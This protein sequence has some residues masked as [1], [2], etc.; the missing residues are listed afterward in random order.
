MTLSVSKS[1]GDNL[2]EGPRNVRIS[3]VN[4]DAFAVMIDQ[5]AK[6]GPNPI[7]HPIPV[8][9]SRMPP[10]PT[11]ATECPTIERKE[12]GHFA[13]VDENEELDEDE[14]GS[15]GLNYMTLLSS[16]IDQVSGSAFEI[17]DTKTSIRADGAE[18]EPSNESDE[19]EGDF[20]DPTKSGDQSAFFGGLLSDAADG[21][22]MTNRKS[23]SG[24]RSKSEQSSNGCAVG[25]RERMNSDPRATIAEPKTTSFGKAGA[26]KSG[27]AEVT[28]TLSLPIFQP[29]ERFH[30]SIASMV[31]AEIAKPPQLIHVVNSTVLHSGT[32]SRA[33]ELRIQIH[34]ENFGR[35]TIQL[36]ESDDC[37][38]VLVRTE[39]EA[40]YTKL[41]SEQE[42]LFRCL[43]A[44]GVNI[45]EVAIEL[46][47]TA[48]AN[49]VLRQAGEI[50]D[51]TFQRPGNR[52]DHRENFRQNISQECTALVETST[53]R[54][55]RQAGI[56]I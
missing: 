25:W 43:R 33:T 22:T 32:H 47:P 44:Q 35:L 6:R 39:S 3:G 51:G 20:T 24:N 29:A 2:P 46:P 53:N 15:Q 40:A 27:A 54:E 49:A 30:S 12:A 23:I 36:R 26:T 19:L 9:H 13:H 38:R 16:G 41:A 55:D 17:M 31:K 18:A 14:A 50:D 10:L 34:P 1:K 28:P 56:Y 21:K 8:N 48:G 11:S 7:K 5:G 4:D 37:L 52:P 42:E 45:S